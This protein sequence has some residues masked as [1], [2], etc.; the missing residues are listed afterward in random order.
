MY[1]FVFQCVQTKASGSDLHVKL[2]HESL[3]SVSLTDKELKHKNEL[4]ASQST[5]GMYRSSSCLL[6]TLFR[7][8]AILGL[9]AFHVGPFI[10]VLLEYGDVCF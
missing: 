10:L 6:N 1:C 9:A 7:E 5:S 2:P 3:L 4:Q 8:E